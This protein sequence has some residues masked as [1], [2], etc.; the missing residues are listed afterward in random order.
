MYLSPSNIP[1]YRQPGPNL[2][3]GWADNQANFSI[4]Y[5]FDAYGTSQEVLIE[6]LYNPDAEDMQAAVEQKM[7]ALEMH[8]E[9]SMAI[10]FNGSSYVPGRWFIAF[11]SGYNGY[12]TTPGV[13]CF[14]LLWLTSL[15]VHRNSL[16]EVQSQRMQKESTPGY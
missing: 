15:L 4:S 11:A 3:S 1:E 13:G 16:P 9:L 2:S 8:L 7:D 12:T 10:A 14:I 6:D 5:A